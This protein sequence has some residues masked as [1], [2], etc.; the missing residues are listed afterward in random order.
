[1][2]GTPLWYEHPNDVEG[3]G[4]RREDGVGTEGSGKVGWRTP[5]KHVKKK[6][7][8]QVMQ[9]AVRSCNSNPWTN[10]ERYINPEMVKISEN[11]NNL[12]KCHK[13]L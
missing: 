8:K 10:L 7:S 9:T 11:K 5:Q 1:M 2:E 4:E 12:F 6:K 3:V 13:N